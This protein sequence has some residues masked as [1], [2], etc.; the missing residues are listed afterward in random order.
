MIHR[1]TRWLVCLPLL[2]GSLGAVAACGADSD[3]TPTRFTGPAGDGEGVYRSNGCSACH[4]T[5]YQ[6]GTGPRL[7]GLAGSTVKLNDGTTVTADAAYLTRAIADPQSQQVDGF[8]LKMPANSLSAEKVAQL[9]ALI[10]A[11]KG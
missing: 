3:S 4:G 1:R 9:V 5:A 7:I 11:L 6:G 8:Q 10:E 2:L